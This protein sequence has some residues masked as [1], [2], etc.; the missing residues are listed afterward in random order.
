[1]SPFERKLAERLDRMQREI[2][3]LE[4]VAGVQE[5][6]IGHL[7]H[8]VKRLEYELRPHHFPATTAVHVKQL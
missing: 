4:L 1:M 8:E 2:Q 3:R 7:E 5:L 6:K